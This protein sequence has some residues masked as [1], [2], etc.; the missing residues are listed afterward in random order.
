MQSELFNYLEKDIR[1]L[2]IYQSIFNSMEPEVIDG[3]RRLTS[4]EKGICISLYDDMRIESIVLHSKGV[5]FQQYQETLPAG[6]SFDFSRDEVNNSLGKPTR[7]GEP[8]ETGMFPTHL[9]WDSY[10][11]PDRYMCIQYEDDSI[12]VVIIRI[13]EHSTVFKM[14]V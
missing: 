8:C 14:M 12:K 11:M 1:S 5:N 2:D 10:Q 13:S 4:L 7:S 9:S 6:L 3:S